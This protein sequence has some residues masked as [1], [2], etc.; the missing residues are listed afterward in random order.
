MGGLTSNNLVYNSGLP[1]L[2]QAAFC[3]VLDIYSQAWQHPWFPTTRTEIAHWYDF[4]GYVP[5]QSYKGEFQ[6]DKVKGFNPV[7]N[8][9]IE[10]SGTKYKIHPVPYKIWMADEDPMVSYQTAADFINW[11]KNAGGYAELRGFKAKSHEPQ[12]LGEDVGIF[13]YLGTDYKLK[14]A[15]KELALWFERFN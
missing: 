3:P 15:V 10:I 6:P 14:P 7:L 2:A 13:T 9:T 1:V 4:N 5:G 8:R 12:D 11:I